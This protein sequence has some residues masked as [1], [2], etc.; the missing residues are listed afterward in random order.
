MR[1]LERVSDASV[2]ITAV[3]NEATLLEEQRHVIFDRFDREYNR[4]TAFHADSWKGRFDL[5]FLRTRC[6]AHDIEWVFNG[7][8]FC[9]LWEPVKKRLNS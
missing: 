9:D 7:L 2:A 8:S 5:P 1:H 6:I 3:D 4:L